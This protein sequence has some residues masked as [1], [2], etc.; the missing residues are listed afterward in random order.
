MLRI[1]AQASRQ[2]LRR[3]LAQ[4]SLPVADHHGNFSERDLK[5]GPAD[6]ALPRRYPGP[7]RCADAHCG[8]RNS[9]SCS[10]FAEC[11]DPSRITLPWPVEISNR[12]RRMKARIKSR[13]TPRPA[14]PD[15]PQILRA[16][17]QKFAGCGHAAARQC[18]RGREIMV[19]SPVNPPALWVTILRSPCQAGLHNLHGPRKQHEKRHAR[20]PRAQTKSRPP[21]SRGPCRMAGCGES[22]MPSAK[23]KLFLIHRSAGEDWAGAARAGIDRA[24]NHWRRHV[25]PGRSKYTH[26]A[27]ATGRLPVR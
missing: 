9:R 12:R 19:I 8:V 1:Q 23:E 26:L 22:A 16:H 25:P 21:S 10:V 14:P 5:T 4:H 20:H 6:P 27:P 18:S 13:S 17:F 15:G 2:F 7:C 24:E 3:R 11:R